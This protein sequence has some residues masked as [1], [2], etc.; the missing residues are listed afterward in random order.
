VNFQSAGK[1][2]KTDGETQNE[3]AVTV[4]G[5]KPDSGMFFKF[6]AIRNV[7]GSYVIF[8]FIYDCFTSLKSI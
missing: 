8:S 5:K 1:I 4:K 3:N 2:N 7:N 6:L